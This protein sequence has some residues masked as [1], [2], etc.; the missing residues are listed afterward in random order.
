LLRIQDGQ[1]RFV[2]PEE[3]RPAGVIPLS[4]YSVSARTARCRR[5]ELFNRFAQI[6]HCRVF[7]GVTLGKSESASLE[8]K[9]I[10]KLMSAP[11][12]DIAGGVLGVLQI[13]R[14]GFDQATAGP[15][16]ANEDLDLLRAV[17]EIV[18]GVMPRLLNQLAPKPVSE[19][20]APGGLQPNFNPA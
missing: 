13:S 4:S 19:H 15:D 1:L 8:P 17:A 3:L 7:E 11:L 16:F 18:A 10:Q 9:A 6:K 2:F 14:K 20:P 12:I 5:A